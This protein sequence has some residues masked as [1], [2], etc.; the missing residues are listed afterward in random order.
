M[1]PISH[2]QNYENLVSKIYDNDKLPWWNILNSVQNYVI[3][4][5]VIH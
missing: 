3:I 4:Y 5:K 2:I 1:P